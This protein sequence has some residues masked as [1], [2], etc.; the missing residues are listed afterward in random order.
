MQA[1]VQRND[2]INM[3][4]EDYNRQV[5]WLMDE[6]QQSCNKDARKKLLSGLISI[7]L[8]LIGLIGYQFLVS[9][10]GT[11]LYA[12]A[13]IALVLAF[14]IFRWI[15]YKRIEHAGSAEE[16]LSIS[17]TLNLSEWVCLLVVSV[18]YCVFSEDSLGT[19]I[20]YLVI[21]VLTMANIKLFKMTDMEANISRL[22][23]LM[24]EGK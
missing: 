19:K 12:I 7:M 11:G 6:I 21:W 16:V 22:R 2:D 18:V 10:D 4:Q 13:M 15:T 3:E 23:E 17:K 1:T 20:F 5:D 9:K 14:F 8:L 24:K